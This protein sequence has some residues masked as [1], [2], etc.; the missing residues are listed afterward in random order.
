M[1]AQ[2]VDRFDG[3]ATPI[4]RF[5]TPCNLVCAESSKLA[6]AVTG[7]RPP[8]PGSPKTAGKRG[9]SPVSSSI[10]NSRK[11][12]AASSLVQGRIAMDDVMIG[13]DVSKDRIDGQIEPGG[14]AFSAGRD[15]EGLT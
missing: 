1:R 4:R 13:I 11:N 8:P 12:R 15:A 3:C 5:A 14:E 10:P 7:E 2:G 6:D 9:V